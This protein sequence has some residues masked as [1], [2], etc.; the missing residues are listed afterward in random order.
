MGRYTG[1]KEKIE[2]RL[3]ERL[4]L[5]GERSLSPKSAIVKKPYPPGMHGRSKFKK[6]S[7]YGIQ[8]MA[9]QKIKNTYRLLEKQF[10]AYIK[11][12]I[13]SKKEAKELIA[14]KLEQRLDNIVY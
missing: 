1:P 10:R 12:A 13:A 7:E 9:K 3:G 5:K 8:L 11:E 6:M 2:R 4:F 14:E